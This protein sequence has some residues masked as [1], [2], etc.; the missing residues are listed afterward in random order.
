MLLGYGTAGIF[1]SPPEQR[2]SRL[3]KAGLALTVAFIAL[4]ALDLYGD[5]HSWDEQSRG[6]IATVMSFFNTEPLR[7]RVSSAETA[8]SVDTWL[9]SRNS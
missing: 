5:P 1:Q 3:L 9:Y 6:M 4:R 7:G 8:C 2:D